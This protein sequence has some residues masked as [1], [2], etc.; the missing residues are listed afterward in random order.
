MKN[1]SCRLFCSSG[2]DFDNFMRQEVSVNE[3]KASDKL[4]YQGDIS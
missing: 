3:R 4:T 2:S 1:K